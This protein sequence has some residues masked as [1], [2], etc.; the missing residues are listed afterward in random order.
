MVTPNLFIIIA[1]LSYVVEGMRT[2]FFADLNTIMAK[3][4]PKKPYI[5]D[6]LLEKKR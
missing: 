2:P 3:S 5:R 6:G 4:S 1:G